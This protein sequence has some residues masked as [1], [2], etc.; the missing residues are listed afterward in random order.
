MLL[1][2]RKT[3]QVRIGNVLVGGDAPIAVQSM[4][5]T[6]TRD[7]EATVAQIHE[8]EAAGCEIIRVAVPT[9]EAAK[10]LSRIKAR[11]HLP[12]VADIHFDYLL[13]LEAIAQG[14]DKIRINPGNILYRDGLAGVEKVVRA[15][16]DAGI[17]IR[18]GVNAGSIDKRLLDKYGYPTPEAAVES[19]VSYVRLLEELDF[20]DIVI[21]VKFS[22]VPQ[23]VRAY[24]LLAQQVDYPL[25]LGVTESGTS[26][27]GAIK[28]AVGIGTLLYDGIGDTLRVSLNTKDKTEEVRVAYEILKSLEIRARGPVLTACPSCGRAEVDQVALASAVEKALEGV[29]KQ[30]RVAVMGCVVNGPG[31]AAGA[32]LAV[33]GGKGVVMI[34]K[35]GQPIRRVKPEDAIPVLLEEIA[36]YEAPEGKPSLGHTYVPR[37]PRA[38]Q[39]RG[40]TEV[41]K[42]LEQA[43]KRG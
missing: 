11:I 28:S 30:V 25:H 3:R 39:L 6:D 42:F 18:V 27:S 10:A 40:H 17:P 38:G 41:V 43:P 29:T 5:D 24:R 35:H 15:C 36:R 9:M 21:S 31:E 4:C 20:H 26:W 2:R 19:A 12:L 13:A 16:K 8:L 37:Q 23:M 22:D 32:D 34:Y 14:A 1:E 33:V 7:V